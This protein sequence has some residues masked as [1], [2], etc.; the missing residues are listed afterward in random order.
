MA[1]PDVIPFIRYSLIGIGDFSHGDNNIWHYRLDLLK[2]VMIETKNR[3]TIFIEDL[4]EHT[5]NIKLDETLIIGD[6]YGVAAGKFPYGPLERYCYRAWDSPIYLKII[7]YVRKHQN[8]INIIGVDVP[9]QAR[10]KAMARNI[11][12]NLNVK[13]INFFW[14]A[15]SHV[16]ARRITESYELKFV[17]NEKYRTG[18]YL[19]KRLKHK[20]CIVLSTGY[21]GE[22]RFSSACNNSDCDIRTFF[23]IPIFEK[24]KHEQYSKWVGVSD[25][26]YMLYKKNEFNEDLVEFADAK[27]PE[28]PFVTK[29]RTWDYLLFFSKVYRLNLIMR[30][31]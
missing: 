20:Y 8:R 9:R 26:R 29:S 6:S 31:S 22:V 19:K 14:A 18:F 24:F 23:E 5:D 25:K 27:F 10:D 2:R 13:H 7:K 17:P 4:D 1:G 30:N 3:I 16:D 15:N 12:K 11:L 28:D 21:Q